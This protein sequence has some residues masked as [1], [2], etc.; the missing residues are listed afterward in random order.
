[1]I[2]KITLTLIVV[3]FLFLP[4]I[5]FA[6]ENYY[7]ALQITP[8]PCGCPYELNE[9]IY[10]PAGESCANDFEDFKSD[11]I[12][13]HFWIRDS[14]ITELGKSDERA[15]QFIY[16]VISHPSIDN[17]PGIL[18]IWRLTR[19]IVYFL[20]I[21]VVA[22]FGLGY[23]IGQRSQFNFGIKIWPAIY[24]TL[25]IL[26]YVTFS[27]SI[28]LF[29]I[30]ISDIL[31]K[32]FIENLKGDQIFNI[33]FTGA[34][35]SEKSYTTFFGCRDLNMNVQEAANAEIFLLK[36]T[37]ITYYVL[38][39]MILLR[40]IILWFMLFV[41]P[42]L[43]LLLPFTFIR[44]IGWI[45]IGVFF[46][47]LFYG[48][49]LALFFGALATIWK[50]GIP[51]LFDFT[52]TGNPDGYIFPTAINIFYGGPSQVLS[53]LNN[54]NYVDTFA[55]YVIT[56]IML[57]A[58]IF[59]PWWLLRIFRDYCCDG[60][61][62]MKNILLSMYDQ[63]R[64]PPSP[65]PSSPLSPSSST[66]TKKIKVS[67]PIEI[68]VKIK[69]ET[70]EEIKKAK[71]EEITRSLNIHAQSLTDIARFETNKQMRET[72]VKNINYLKNPLQAE[73]PTQR[74]KFMNL[75]T[76]LYQRSLKQDILAKNI[77]SSVSTSVFEQQKVKQNVIEK[78]P[79]TVPINKI[80]TEKTK[81]PE[82]K[83]NN[84]IN[85][86]LASFA[87]DNQ[88]IN[89]VSQSTNLTAP[90]INNI[91]NSFKIHIS[92]KPTE[93]INKI[94]QDTGLNKEQIIAVIKQIKEEVK[95][96][97]NLIDEISQKENL[98]KETIKETIETPINLAAEPEKHI[99]QTITIPPTVS[100][101]EYE[102]VKKMWVDHYERGELPVSENITNRKE[103]VE[104]DI[105]FITNT[106]NKLLSEDAKLK[107]EGLD[108]VSYILPIFLI[109]NLSG[110]QLV[111]YL[112]A[113]L[114]AAK[115][116]QQLFEKEE[117]IKEKL[118][119]QTEEK[120]EVA[121]KKK[122]EAAK[123]MEMGMEIEEETKKEDKPENP[124]EEKGTN[125][126]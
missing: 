34:Q 113:K 70:I 84:I 37:N 27:A 49:L 56:L 10:R 125:V 24:K 20:T 102:Q 114:E 61:Y 77:V 69:L 97:T 30:Q 94:N 45:W 1:M 82:I 4:K 119:S 73:T 76:E 59:F 88:F 8:I 62:A 91:L 40:K 79:T 63:M 72:V 104:R 31:M 126:N 22:L 74:Q 32:F 89:K 85:S 36:A 23:I 71:T 39:I 12:A 16:W 123:E 66:V 42:F 9:K 11:P 109:N 90:Q 100:I 52:R 25:L 75:K 67:E 26:L 17:H 15:R 48:P 54:G 112:K 43:A 29:L 103:W 60:I 57:W 120:V 111:A 14:K 80:L 41:S 87:S 6:D 98:P 13:K 106:L 53:I 92:E 99:E 116:V 28:V 83:T 2:K 64:N 105:I 19:N 95:E 117:E 33:Y 21:L 55:E 122:A 68:P 7:S 65:Q 47:W 108:D 101:D 46:Q 81:V 86:T 93:I 115:Q 5:I 50:N 96:K 110:E 38:G 107:Q 124:P 121:A 51:F 44:N 35:S 78:I 18:S 58:V 118:K 3:I